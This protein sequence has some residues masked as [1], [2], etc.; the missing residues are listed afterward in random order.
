M[1]FTPL[2]VMSNRD[3]QKSIDSAYT[4]MRIATLEQSREMW[5]IHLCTLLGIQV[6]RAS[7]SSGIE[8]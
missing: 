1:T 5:R 4:H 2:H 8:P 3:L 6:M 7:Q